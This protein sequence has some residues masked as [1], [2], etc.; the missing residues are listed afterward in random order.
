MSCKLCSSP[1]VSFLSDSGRTSIRQSFRYQV[2]FVISPLCTSSRLSWSG[3]VPKPP[4][5]RSLGILAMAQGNGEREKWLMWLP[6]G[7]VAERVFRLI[8]GAM[9]SPVGQYVSSPVTFLHVVD[10]RV[11]LA[12]LLAL[13][14]LPSRSHIVMRF[15]LVA[16]LAVMSVWVLPKDVWTDQLGRVTLL[17]GILFL[18]LGFGSDSAPPLV[19]LRTPPPS[20]MGLPELPLS[21]YSY[22]ILKLGPLQL[23]RKGLSVASTSACLSFTIFQSASLCLT[24]TTPEQLAY[25]LQW[26]MIPLKFVGVPVAEI[27]LTLLLS[28][29]FISIVFDEVRNAAMAIVSRRIKWEQLTVME[30]LDIFI[31]YVRRIFA[32]I[33]KHAEQITQAMIVRGF[34]GDSNIHKIYFFSNT[35][36]GIADMISLLGLLGLIGASIVSEQIL[37]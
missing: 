25:A 32:N 4:K 22:S 13:V 20:L 19:Q 35:S 30:T 33:F 2:P 29:R 16:F 37:V 3:K 1:T 12:W 28:L 31:M 8:A 26:F 10:S 18:M 14:V 7:P 9:S 11:K 23:T 34:R 27:I 24:T 15:G 17:S 5:R 21:G 6:R 36:F